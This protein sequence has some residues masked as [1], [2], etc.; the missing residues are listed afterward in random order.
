M[1]TNLETLQDDISSVLFDLK[2]LLEQIDHVTGKL[3]YEFGTG[4]REECHQCCD[5]I[6]SPPR[7]HSHT[8]SP[9]SLCLCSSPCDK[10]SKRVIMSK[11]NLKCSPEQHSVSLRDSFKPSKLQTSQSYD[12]DNRLRVDHI[13][14]HDIS[15]DLDLSYLH[16]SPGGQRSNRSRWG[17]SLVL[18]DSIHSR[19]LET[20]SISSPV[21]IESYQYKSSDSETSSPVT[22][23]PM[24]RCFTQ[25]HISVADL[26]QYSLCENDSCTEEIVHSTGSTHIQGNEA[27]HATRTSSIKTSS[28]SQGAG[29][30]L[31]PDLSESA[32][33]NFLD[34]IIGT[35]KLDSSGSDI[36]YIAGDSVSPE[37]DDF[38]DIASNN[39]PIDMFNSKYVNIDSS[40]EHDEDDG[41]D[42]DN[43][44]EDL[45]EDQ[46]E[47]LSAS[48]TCSSEYTDT[49]STSERNMELG[50]QDPSDGEF[51]DD[52]EAR[53][54]R[55]INTWTSY[56]VSHMNSSMRSSDSYLSDT[57]SDIMNEN[58]SQAT[59]MY[60]NMIF[61]DQ[62]VVY[63]SKRNRSKNNNTNQIN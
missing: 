13:R 45:M 52:I 44:Y 7:S 43:V 25:E 28:S 16:I 22:A 39:I 51:S 48:G 19:F 36:G 17:R 14:L 12:Q 57:P 56:T 27:A 54:D 46:L 3:D 30:T 62:L 41:V 35:D 20:R 53:Y 50:S 34:N 4:W 24:S 1:V 6:I 63:N 29:N 23:I 15:P 18:P 32:V 55:G 42:Y 58:T 8:G 38:C 37:V 10:D 11:L 31:S 40:S 61:A 60:G 2:Q 59:R 26:A 9:T 33:L 21:P 5:D 49:T 47:N